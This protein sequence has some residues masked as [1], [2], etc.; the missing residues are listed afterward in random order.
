MPHAMQIIADEIALRRG[1]SEAS[2]L[3]QVHL[4]DATQLAPEAVS[5]RLP[6]RAL[7]RARGGDDWIFLQE[8]RGPLGVRCVGIEAATEC[9]SILVEVDRQPRGLA[10]PRG[11]SVPLAPRRVLRAILEVVADV[12]E[13]HHLQCLR[14]GMRVPVASGARHDRRGSGTRRRSIGRAIARSPAAFGGLAR[15]G[16]DLAFPALR[17]EVVLECRSRVDR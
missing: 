6:P 17:L 8:N 13:V 2:V 1:A 12:V 11:R 14:L 7:G 4:V 9:W 3:G 5:W 16:R 15:V 10:D